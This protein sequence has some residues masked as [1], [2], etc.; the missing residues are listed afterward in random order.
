[1]DS[2]WIT[3][4]LIKYL[5]LYLIVKLVEPVKQEVFV[6][7]WNLITLDG[8]RYATVEHDGRI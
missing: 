4:F 8:V 1:M 5:F 2:S 3:D 7:E 6:K